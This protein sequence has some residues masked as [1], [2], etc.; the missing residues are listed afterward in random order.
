MA[1]EVVLP[2]L[3]WN[4]ESGRLGEWLKK[5]GERVQTGDILFTVEGDKAVQE[6]EALDSGIL[7]IPPD[8]PPPGQ[9]IPVGTLLAYLVADGEPPPFAPPGPPS[10]VR[11][12]D[13]RPDALTPPPPGQ[14]ADDAQEPRHEGGDPAISP[15]A[16]RLARE[17]GLDWRALK[18][19][20]RTGRIIERDVRQ[21]RAQQAEGERRRAE[22]AITPVARRVAHE[23]GVDAE[24][25]AAQAP[26]KRLRRADIEAEAGRTHAAG[27]AQGRPIG[28]AQ[29][30]PMTPVRRLIAERMAAS[31]HTTAAVTLTTE[32]DATELVRLRQQLQADGGPEPAPSYNDIL[33][34]LVAQ[35]LLEHPLLNARIEG[36]MI[37]PSATANIGL[38]VDT[39]RGLLVPVLR[40]VQTKSL[41][42][43]ARE[44]A[45]LVEQART[46]RIAAGD[47][48]GGT[49][50]ITNL[51]MYEID[52]F[53]PIINLPECA[54]LGVGRIVARQVVVDAEA[55]EVAS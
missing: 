4:M 23:L 6:V 21:A 27:Q 18:G 8:S 1:F 5:D 20:G 2:R 19:S 17:L 43:V 38:A 32:V 15:R 14:R 37:V 50:T 10:P 54:I 46:G 51:G 13:D 47:L 42:Q 36:E 3:G 53:T 48:A 35:A 28:Q 25:L 31:A 39:E 34:R 24:A 9:E 33:A 16:R 40:D 12:A 44:A 52:V 29:G 22:I 49:F 11:P 30:R 7:R 55:E 26:G 41:R 45:A